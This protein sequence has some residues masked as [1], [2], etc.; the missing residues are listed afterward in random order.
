M[1]IDF[2]EEFPVIENLQKA[3]LINHS[4]LVYLAARS[5][6]EFDHLAH[7]LH[8]LNPKLQA[9]YWPILKE[10][11]WI[12]PFS[13]TTELENLKGELSKRNSSLEVLLDLEL[14]IL[15]PVL[16]FK[17]FHSFKRNRDLIKD[18][19]LLAID[20]NIRFSTAEYPFV[21]DMG[22]FIMWAAGIS[23]STKFYGHERIIMSYSSIARHAF[24]PLNIDMR[25]WLRRSL[26][27]GVKRDNSIA[28]GLGTIATGALGNEPILSLHELRSDLEFCSEL[29]CKRVVVFRLGGLNEE[30]VSVISSFSN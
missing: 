9:G 14:P 1:R 16:F 25:N 22:R 29:K 23:Y 7:M 8:T 19:L 13:Y 28:I 26:R 11:Y 30:Y 21:A 4:S 27:I 3:V 24:R 12:S 10:S 6:E 20:T 5:I 18:I 2:F 15:S 17:N